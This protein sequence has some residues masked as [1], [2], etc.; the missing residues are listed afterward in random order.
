MPGSAADQA[1][2]GARNVGAHSMWAARVRDLDADPFLKPAS[3][4]V[5][6]MD[7][8][9]A[10]EICGVTDRPGEQLCVGSLCS[11]DAGLLQ[12]L[13]DPGG[14]ELPTFVGP[15]EMEVSPQVLPSVVWVAVALREGGDP[16]TIDLVRD[17]MADVGRDP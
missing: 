15:E 13:A 11:P 12:C 3:G 2:C 4:R 8:R 14:T 16:A 9:P 10:P 5:L 7:L 17:L 1:G 6:L